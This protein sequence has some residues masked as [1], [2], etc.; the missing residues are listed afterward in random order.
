MKTAVV[1][2]LQ[3]KVKVNARRIVLPALPERVFL[4]HENPTRETGLRKSWVV[5]DALSGVA[6]AMQWETTERQ[7]DV[8]NKAN[9][10]IL[11][12]V[13]EGQTFDEYVK[14]FM[15]MNNQRPLMSNIKTFA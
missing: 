7:K 2:T 3:G 8:I 11:T 6:V 15:R 4:L 12:R 14:R 9:E 5:T 13:P 10:A 1:R